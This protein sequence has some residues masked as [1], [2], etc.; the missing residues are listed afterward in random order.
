MLIKLL[1]P[2]STEGVTDSGL[3]ERVAFPSS[4]LVNDDSFSARA[5]RLIASSKL[6][7]AR[8]QGSFCANSCRSN[9]V[10][11]SFCFSSDVLGSLKSVVSDVCKV[12]AFRSC[13]LC[14]AN[15]SR[16]C[17]KCFLQSSKLGILWESLQPSASA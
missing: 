3:F 15:S 16:F 2:A 5:I 1:H 6:R 10:I 8:Y 9:A 11:R 7:F 4:W 14:S 12:F 17:S 13:Y